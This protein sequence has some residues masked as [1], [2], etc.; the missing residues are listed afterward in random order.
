V[1][2][3]DPGPTGGAAIWQNSANAFSLNKTFTQISS[4][5]SALGAIF[6][7]PAF[8]SFSGTLNSPQ[9]QEWNLQVQRQLNNSL[10]FTANYVGN[11]GIHIPYTDAWPNAYDEYGL[12]PGVKG[13]P[14]APRVP[15]YGQVTTVQTG[16][17]SNYNGLNLSLTKRYSNWVSG[18]LNY[19]WSHGLDEVSNGGLFSDGNGTQ[20]QIS[21]LSLRS[22]NYGNSDYD[23]RHNMN[24]D[25]VITPMPKFSNA[26][27]TNVLG[28]WQISGKLFWRSGL[29]FSVTDDDTALGNGGGALFATYTGKGLGQSSCGAGAAVTPCLNAAA[30]VDS[31]VA[32]FTAYSGLS[33]QNR[34]QYRGPHYFDMDMAV[35]K[36]FKLKGENGPLLGVGFQAFNF[37]N[38]P[39]F[40]LPDA[41][42]TDSTFGLISSMASTTTSPYGSFLG[43]DSSPRIFQLSAKI[44]F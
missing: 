44:S 10:V 30:F 39:N 41:G 19:T 11:H 8:T 1:A 34:N 36:N 40:G 23:I 5:L 21:P 22:L 26:F 2:V 31:T 37:F 4:Q 38:H 14:S 16:A 9:F 24:G 3:Y 33:S 25:F 6:A 12:Y 17:V 35:F 7:A 32:S 28:N 15:N 13:I 20:G 27:L 43:F 18:H 42:V 29:P